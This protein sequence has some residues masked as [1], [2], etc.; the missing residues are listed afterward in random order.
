MGPKGLLGTGFA[1]GLMGMA[2]YKMSLFSAF[3]N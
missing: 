2:F 1:G 3:G